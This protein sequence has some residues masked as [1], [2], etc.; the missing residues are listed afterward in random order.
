MTENPLRD[1]ADIAE[2]FRNAVIADCDRMPGHESACDCPAQMEVRRLGD[3]LV[4]AI[5]RVRQA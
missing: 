5:A 2:R 3:E 4:A 1:L